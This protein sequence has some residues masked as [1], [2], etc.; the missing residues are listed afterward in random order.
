MSKHPS[1]R[2]CLPLISFYPGVYTTFIFSMPL[3][4]TCMQVVNNF[5]E[6][7]NW[8]AYA[9]WN[10]VHPTRKCKVKVWLC[11]DVQKYNFDVITKHLA[12]VT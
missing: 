2:G 1:V 9:Y 11:S 10:Q 5:I 7:C 6:D 8:N 3:S 4:Y 12:L